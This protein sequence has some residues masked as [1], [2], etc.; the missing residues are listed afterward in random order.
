MVAGSGRLPGW[1]M[2]KK[3][4]LFGGRGLIEIAVLTGEQLQDQKIRRMK[5]GHGNMGQVL[6]TLRDVIPDQ[7]AELLH[8]HA[9]LLGCFG[10][11]VLGL[12]WF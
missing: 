10:L 2:R 6:I 1:V 9:K 8:R 5:T 12:T 4:A 7:D 3:W 11:G